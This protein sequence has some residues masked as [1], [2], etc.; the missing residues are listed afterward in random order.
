[1]RKWEKPLLTVDDTANEHLFGFAAKVQVG[2][3][4]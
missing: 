2:A 4:K 3:W 1:M